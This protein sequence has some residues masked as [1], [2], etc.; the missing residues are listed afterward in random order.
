MATAKQVL[1]AGEALAGENEAV[2]GANNTT[3]N[4]EAGLPGSPY[5]GGFVA[6]AQKHGGSALLNKCS[7]PWYVPTLRQYMEAQGWPRVSTPQPGDIFIEGDDMHTGYCDEYLGNGYFMT[8][9]GNGGHVKASK[10]D[11]RNGTGSTY[12]GIGYR[13]AAVSGGFKFYRPPYDGTSS[14]TPAPAPAPEPKKAPQDYVK[15]WQTW[16]GVEADGDPGV[17]TL[18]ASVGRLLSGLLS[19]HYL[20]RGD[21]GDAVKV[22]QGLL[23]A[24]DYDP[25]GLD[26]S[27]GPG[28][29]AAVKKFQADHGLDADGEAGKDTVAALLAALQ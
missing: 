6:Y 26:G 4:R 2:L 13:R 5:C 14:G 11:A 22:V 12:E 8:L 10:A 18:T 28:M 24:L 7:N 19:L 21:K 27:Y 29:E 20:R 3:V 17:K 9:E 25:D 1:A 16:L 15:D 23:Y